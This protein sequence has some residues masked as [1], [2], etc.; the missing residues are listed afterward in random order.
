MKNKK[1]RKTKAKDV[2]S[3]NSIDLVDDD[4]QSTVT[5]VYIGSMTQHFDSY[6]TKSF[7]N[8]QNLKSYSDS[9]LSVKTRPS[10]IGNRTIQFL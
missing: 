10:E 7:L 9:T 6:T 1:S 8:K 4:L 5:Y 3:S 2:K